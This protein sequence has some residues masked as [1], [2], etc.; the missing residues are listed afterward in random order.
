M[1]K[2]ARITLFFF[3]TAAALCILFFIAVNTGSIKVSAVQL[4]RGIFVE[5]D[6]KV[7]IIYDLRLPRI[8]IAILAGAGLAVS[9]VLL[10]AVLQNPLADPGIIGITGGAEFFAVLSSMLFPSLI[11]ATSTFAFLGGCLAFCI[12]YSI[13][14]KGGLKAIRIILVGIAVNAMFEGLSEVINSSSGSNVSQVAS[15]VEG[16][17]SLKT[18]S[19]VKVLAAF[20]LIGLIFAM[21]VSGRC[22]LLVLEDKT[23]LGLG[24]K[25]GVIRMYISIIAVFLACMCTVVTGGVGF[26]ALIVPHLGRV[27]VGRE[28]KILIPFT[29]FLGACVYLA[30]DT[31]G[32][33]A[34]YPYEI[35][36]TVIMAVAGGPCFIFLLRRSKQ[37]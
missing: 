16:N 34:A 26:L 20:V 7:S 14:W 21:M 11:L 5:Y 25:V 30:A 35:S 3:I 10:Q 2:K 18:W 28:H 23:I 9:G 19:D 27:L 1:N 32:R 36:A 31:I 6:E 13:S 15:I 12:V 4:F 17:I 33:A 24:L 22:N 37:V 8:L 29:A